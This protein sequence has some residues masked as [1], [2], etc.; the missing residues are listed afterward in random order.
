MQQLVALK[1]VLLL[2][3]KSFIHVVSSFFVRQS[4]Q[5]ISN[6]FMRVKSADDFTCY[7]YM[8]I[9]SNM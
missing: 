4:I 6:L 9:F 8:S 2:D 5:F 7:P 3:V 1:H